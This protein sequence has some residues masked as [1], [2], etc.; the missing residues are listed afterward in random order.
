MSTQCAFAIGF[1]FGQWNEDTHPSGP[2][3][4]VLASGLAHLE[5]SSGRYICRMKSGASPQVDSLCPK[6]SLTQVPGV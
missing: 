2:H 3:F 1:L 6:D 4:G 5:L